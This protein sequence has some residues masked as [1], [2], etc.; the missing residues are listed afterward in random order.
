MPVTRG[1]NVMDIWGTA[2]DGVQQK[3]Y[4]WA[5]MSDSEIRNVVMPEDPEEPTDPVDPTDPEEPTEPTDPTDPEEPTDPTEPVD[6]VDPVDPTE[7]TGPT[8]PTDPTNPTGPTDPTEPV[9]PTGPTDPAN[10][11]EDHALTLEILESEN[12]AATEF[13]RGQ[14]VKL[15]L[16]GVTPNAEVTFE[17]HSDVVT[18]PT[19]AADEQGVASTE[20]TVPADYALGA[21]AVVARSGEASV[22]SAIT[23]IAHEEESGEQSDNGDHKSETAD[24][25]QGNTSESDK[26]GKEAVKRRVS[27][28]ASTGANGAFVVLVA[29]ATVA[30]GIVLMTLRR[31]TK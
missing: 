6:P 29:L 1:I 23:I 25:D 21:H 16:S 9:D 8:D 18:L 2:P 28:L 20:W 19:V 15:R 24:S 3:V 22:E 31:K 27:A 26:G 4:R 5:T 14:V 10:P 7:P 11:G 17:I 13:K 30:G 12:N